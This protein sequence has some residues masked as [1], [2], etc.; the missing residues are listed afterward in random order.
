MENLNWGEIATS[1][2]L[3]VLTVI[4][5]PL[6]RTW[7][8]S[9][10]DERIRRIGTSAVGW[11]EQE[12]KKEMLEG[13]RAVPGEEKKGSAVN[14]ALELATK[15]GIKVDREKM[16]NVVEEALGALNLMSGKK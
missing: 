12:A 15:S 16:E 5:F 8:A 13:N 4:I 1:G 14:Y 9:I 7:I 11:A 10:K 3:L 6:V 2:I